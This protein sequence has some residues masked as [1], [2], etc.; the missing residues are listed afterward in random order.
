MKNGS[1][2]GEQRSTFKT[3]SSEFTIANNKQEFLNDI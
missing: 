2:L 1:V 3:R